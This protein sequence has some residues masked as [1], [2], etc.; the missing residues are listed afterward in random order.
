MATRTDSGA[1][2]AVMKERGQH[3]RDSIDMDKIR[4]MQFIPKTKGSWHHQYIY[5]SEDRG[6]DVIPLTGEMI[7]S[8]LTSPVYGQHPHIDVKFIKKCVIMADALFLPEFINPFL[9]KCKAGSFFNIFPHSYVVPCNDPLHRQTS[10]GFVEIIDKSQNALTL[11]SLLADHELFFEL[12]RIQ[13]DCISINIGLSDIKQENLSWHP[14]QIPKEYLKK[15]QELITHMQTYFF[16]A[17]SRGAFAENLTYTFNLLPVYAAADSEKHNLQNIYQTVQHTNLWGTTYYGITREFYKHISDEINR[18][19]HS[20]K[21][22]MFNKFQVVMF[23][24]TPKWSFEDLH[25]DKRSGLPYPEIH[26]QMLQIFFYCLSR[27]VC[28]RKICT[29]GV[30]ASRASRNIDEQLYEGCTMLYMREYGQMY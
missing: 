17:G 10:V 18:K 1:D 6:G 24:P 19:L 29:L 7:D 9:I 4:G 28:N 25:V 16:G 30:N 26:H 2:L 5:R 11:G 27:F 23:N 13:P 15:F 12:L 21:A 3:A 14:N 8:F 20:C 22:E